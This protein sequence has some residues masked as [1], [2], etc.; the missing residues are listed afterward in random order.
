MDFSN[1]QKHRATL[2]LL[3]ETLSFLERMPKAPV[4]REFCARLQAHLDEPTQ[5]LVATVQ[6][7]LRGTGPFTPAGVPLLEASLIDRSLTIGL[8]TEL[9]PADRPYALQE[10]SRLLAAGTISLGLTPTN[11]H[12]E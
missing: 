9:R 3:R 10:I 6:R 1:D 5:R 2:D 8:P 4:T 12:P 11:R 7:E